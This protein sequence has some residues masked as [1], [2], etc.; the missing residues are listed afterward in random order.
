MST[1]DNVHPDMS[2]PETVP[3]AYIYGNKG[4]HEFLPE[5]PRYSTLS[6]DQ[7]LDR[8]NQPVATKTLDGM[9]AANDSCMGIIEQ[10]GLVESLVDPKRRK[11]LTNI[12]QSLDNRHLL[13]EVRYGVLGPTMDIVT[14]MLEVTADRR[15]KGDPAYHYLTQRITA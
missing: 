6:D 4:K 8:A 1:P 14:E 15:G 5:R 3:P 10:E 2:T 13:K 7:V 12:C 9:A 11:K